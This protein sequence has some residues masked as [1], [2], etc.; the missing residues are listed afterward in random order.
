[1]TALHPTFHVSIQSYRYCTCRPTCIVVHV[2]CRL[3]IF[4]RFAFHVIKKI[5]ETFNFSSLRRIHVSICAFGL[6]AKLIR[7]IKSSEPWRNIELLE[8]KCSQNTINSKLVKFSLFIVLS[9]FH[10]TTMCTPGTLF[11]YGSELSWSFSL[12]VKITLY[13]HITLCF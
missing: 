10:C 11:L 9:V 2:H 12:L 1:M 3:L 7:L 6:F 8:H 4:E 13:S 5:I